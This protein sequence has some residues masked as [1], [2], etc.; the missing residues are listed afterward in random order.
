ML[1]IFGQ[2][3][4]A[5]EG[6][7]KHAVWPMG[8]AW[9]CTHLWEHYSY[10]LD[11]N[12]LEQKAYPLLK[13]CGEFLLDSLVEYPKGVLVTNPSTSPE[14]LF[15]APD[16]QQASVSYAIAMDMAIIKEIFIATI[17]AAEVLGNTND[18]LIQ[19]MKAAL[20]NLFPP[21]VSQDGSLMEWAQDF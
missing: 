4:Y 2:K 17:S 21:K 9:L 10:T 7:P 11:K 16:G 15:I 8:G 13:G 20:P 6:N 3:T 5:S 19:K 14:H 1:Q 18:D 12:F